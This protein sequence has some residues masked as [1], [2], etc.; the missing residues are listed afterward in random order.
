[1]RSDELEIRANP[2]VPRTVTEILGELGGECPACQYDLTGSCDGW[3]PECGLNLGAALEKR[4]EEEL[5]RREVGRE[6][7]R[8][9][10]MLAYFLVR[11]TVYY[12][13][14]SSAARHLSLFVPESAWDCFLRY[15]LRTS[16]DWITLA[17]RCFTTAWAVAML[18]LMLG[19]A[20]VGRT[21][22]LDRWRRRIAGFTSKLLAVEALLMGW[23]IGEWLWR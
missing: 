14:V 18:L 11:G 23:W 4:R 21:R 12:L 20:L 15:E 7:S 16:K 3:C 9:T 2:E 19:G 1:M 8:F 17:W 13:G 5:R 10:W 22:A 6:T